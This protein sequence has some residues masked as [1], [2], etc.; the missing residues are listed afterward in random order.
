MK[1]KPKKTISSFGGAV[2]KI[3]QSIKIEKTNK[4]SYVCL[5]DGQ[6]LISSISARDKKE[7]K[8]FFRAL[9]KPLIFKLFTFSVLCA[10]LIFK[11]RA[12]VVLIDEEYSGHE[13]DIKSFI[14]QLLTIWGNTDTNISLKKTG[15]FMNSLET[16]DYV[17][18]LSHPVFNMFILAQI[19]KKCNGQID[20]GT[21]RYR[22]SD[23]ACRQ[24][25]VKIFNVK[26][27]YYK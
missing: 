21:I 7:L 3:D 9:D 2:F 15:C 17:W 14:I 8:L 18:L 20:P 16:N 4:T 25:G 19:M 6:I 27:H 11:A 13:I 5:A 24:A 1:I 22:T 23:L 10:K 12:K 26:L